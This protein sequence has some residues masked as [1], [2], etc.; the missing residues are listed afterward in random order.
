MLVETSLL[1]PIVVDALPVT[2]A[3]SAAPTVTTTLPVTLVASAAPTH[4]CS[5][6]Q[7]IKL[8]KKQQTLDI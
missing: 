6:L 7:R 5:L 1:S 3:A 2:L 4:A 8:A